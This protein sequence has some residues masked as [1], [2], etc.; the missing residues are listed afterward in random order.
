[1]SCSGRLHLVILLHG[2][3]GLRYLINLPSCNA[4]FEM[5]MFALDMVSKTISVT[6]ERISQLSPLQDRILNL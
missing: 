5:H 1:M 2:H 3:P 6:S 4:I